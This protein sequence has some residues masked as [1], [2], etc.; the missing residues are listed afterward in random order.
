MYDLHQFR[1]V[2]LSNRQPTK[3]YRRRY[4]NMNKKQKTK[5]IKIKNRRE[6]VRLFNVK[7]KFEVF[8]QQMW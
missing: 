1:L 4:K 5:K 2:T 7:E 8:M 6:N 3:E